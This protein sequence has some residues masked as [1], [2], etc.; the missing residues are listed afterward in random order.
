MPS[1]TNPKFIYLLSQLIKVI[2]SARLDLVDSATTMCIPQ[3]NANNC[4]Q[5]ISTSPVD[6]C[7]DLLAHNTLTTQ[8]RLLERLAV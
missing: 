2:L 1:P 7:R 8:S 6:K 4:L 5:N 3:P